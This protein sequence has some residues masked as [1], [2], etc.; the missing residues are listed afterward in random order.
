[1]LDNL[2]RNETYEE[3]EALSRDRDHFQ[4]LTGPSLSKAASMMK[5]S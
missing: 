4:N 1:M 5:L 2:M 3:T